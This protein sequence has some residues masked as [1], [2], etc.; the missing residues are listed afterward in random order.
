MSAFSLLAPCGRHVRKP[1]HEWWE[2]PRR[3]TPSWQRQSP[4]AL[5]AEAISNPPPSWAPSWCQLADEAP[6]H[7]AEQ[8]DL[9]WPKQKTCEQIK[10]SAFKLRSSRVVCYMAI[11]NWY[12]G[13]YLLSEKAW[14]GRKKPPKLLT[15]GSQGQRHCGQTLRFVNS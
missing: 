7:P 2:T 15:C 14:V 11:D 12:L 13:E 5:W 9:A 6:E 10:G 1:R 4:Q 3:E 8:P